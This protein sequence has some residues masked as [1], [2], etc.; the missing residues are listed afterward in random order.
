MSIHELMRLDTLFVIV[1]GLA[2]GV[3]ILL[4]GRLP[5]VRRRGA[6]LPTVPHVSGDQPFPES[7]ASE[8]R[9]SLRRRGRSVRVLIAEENSGEEPTEG[10]VVD[11]S[12]GGLSVSL[13]R[14]VSVG[15]LVIVRAGEGPQTLPSI[16]AQVRS[17]RPQ[18][19]SW[20]LGLAF[21]KT[22]PWGVLLH[23][24]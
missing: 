6:Y 18:G 2:C 13:P 17:C 14:E 15:R 12:T 11:R 8:R 3:A 4:L 22:P 20:E 16:Q 9:A 21:V 5:F 23:F 19:D 10:Y 7:S 24:G 1:A